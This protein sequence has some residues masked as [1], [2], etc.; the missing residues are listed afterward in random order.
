MGEVP[1]SLHV[2]AQL[3]EKLEREA[4]LQDVSESEI[5]ARAIK[6]FLNVQAHM[7]DFIEAAAEEADR[8]P[9]VSSEAVLDWMSRLEEDIDAPAPQPDVFLP[10]RR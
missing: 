9:F 10:R 4:R 3:K 1:L 7:R 6:A 2:D 8:G 5:A